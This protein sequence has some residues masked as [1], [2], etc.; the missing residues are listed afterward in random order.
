[1]FH[2]FHKNM[3]QQTAFNIDIWYKKYLLYFLI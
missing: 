3:M 2:S 1:M